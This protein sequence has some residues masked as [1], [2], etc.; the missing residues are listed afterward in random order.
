LSREPL[1]DV[2]PADL[3]RDYV[4]IVAALRARGLVRTG[5]VVGDYAEALVC[6]ALGLVPADGPMRGY[7]AI[8]PMTKHRY[9]IKARRIG[10]RWRDAGMGP[11]RDLD[12]DLFDVFVGVVVDQD[13]EVVRAVSLPKWIVSG[14]GHRVAYDGTHRI[15]VGPGLLE[16]DGVT[17]VTE[18]LR[19][20][21]AT[22]R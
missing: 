15:N 4:R 6:R 19:E 20:A 22:W 8:D 14:H 17:D 7:D 5:K 18:L 2:S 21:A 13:F 3:L 10:P 11:F 9:Q 16:V 12:R 1:A